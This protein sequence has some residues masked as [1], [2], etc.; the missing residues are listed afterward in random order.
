MMKSPGKSVFLQHR[1]RSVSGTRNTELRLETNPFPSALLCISRFQ[2]YHFPMFR[3]KQQREEAGIQPVPFLAIPVLVKHVGRWGQGV[4][5]LDGF[6]A[7]LHTEVKQMCS[8]AISFL[9]NHF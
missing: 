9:P 3:V 2:L 5:W 1:K 8:Q 6:L 7:W 4:G